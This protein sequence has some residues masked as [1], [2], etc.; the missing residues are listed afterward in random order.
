MQVF[1][2]GL[3]VEQHLVQLRDDPGVIRAQRSEAIDQHPQHRETV[4]SHGA[5]VAVNGSRWLCT[6][7]QPVTLRISRSTSTTP[8]TTLRF[9]RS[10]IF[11]PPPK[12]WY[13][14]VTMYV[15]RGVTM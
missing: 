14:L 3:V 5:S 8:P 7:G 2:R 10:Q 11:R 12:S 13:V 4:Q 1:A 6:Y 9:N 15:S